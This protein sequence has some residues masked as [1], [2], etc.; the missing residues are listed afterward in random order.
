[1]SKA[2]TFLSTSREKAMFA[3]TIVAGSAASR[4]SV[5]ASQA[6]CRQPIHG[7]TRCGAIRTPPA[8]ACASPASS[9]AHMPSTQSAGGRTSSS[10]NK[11]K[12]PRAAASPALRAKHCPCRG[13]KR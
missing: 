2:G 4:L 3:P 8:T 11:M 6:L 12:R 10:V 5:E 13:S 7:R 1:V 9:G